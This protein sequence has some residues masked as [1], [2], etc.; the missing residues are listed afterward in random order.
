MLGIEPRCLVWAVT[1]WPSC[2]DEFYHPFWIEQFTRQLATDL[3]LT[4]YEKQSASKGSESKHLLLYIFY[5]LC[6]GRLRLL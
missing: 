1:I 4:V 5:F 3:I 6:P 2:G